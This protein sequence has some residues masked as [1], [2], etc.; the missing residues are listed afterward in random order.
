MF[1]SKLGVTGLSS[2]RYRLKQNQPLWDLLGASKTIV[3]KYIDGAAGNSD[4]LIEVFHPETHMFGHIGDTSRDA[5]ISSFIKLV[6]TSPGPQIGPNYRVEMTRLNVVG[7]AAA[8]TLVK[9]DYFGCDFVNYF[10]FAKIDDEWEIVS[11]TFT[12]TG[13]DYK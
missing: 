4:A 5:L 7:L 6:S 11:K 2:F 3:Q 13:G 1:N 12:C 8:V 10:T 9:Q